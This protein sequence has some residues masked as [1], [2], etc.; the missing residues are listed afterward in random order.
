MKR[1]ERKRNERKVG[2]FDV[3][4]AVCT[5]YIYMYVYVCVCVLKVDGWIDR[6]RDGW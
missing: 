2:I 3:V 1:D 6:W 5:V 4:S